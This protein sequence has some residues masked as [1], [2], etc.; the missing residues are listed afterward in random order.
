MNDERS[1]DDVQVGDVVRGLSQSTQT[2]VNIVVRERKY[3]QFDS[4]RHPT[5]VGVRGFQVNDDGTIKSRHWHYIGKGLPGRS[6]GSGGG[7]PDTYH[8]DPLTRERSYGGWVY[9]PD[10]VAVKFERNDKWA[11]PIKELGV[12]DTLDIDCSFGTIAII[13]SVASQQAGKWN[14]RYKVEKTLSGCAVTRKA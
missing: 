9:R 3:V 1:P 14:R 5:F 6:D 8:E 10:I 12:G 4:D 13:R 11:G 7:M 2:F